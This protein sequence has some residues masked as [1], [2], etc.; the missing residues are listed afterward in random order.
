MTVINLIIIY[1]KEKI[2]Y[3]YFRFNNN[4]NI[5]M[6]NNNNRNSDHIDHMIRILVTSYFEGKKSFNLKEFQ[7][8]IYRLIYDT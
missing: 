8:S 3:N 6:I 1:I 7:L 5:K 2:Y 4:N